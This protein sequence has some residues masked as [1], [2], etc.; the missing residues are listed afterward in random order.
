[1]TEPIESIAIIGGGIGGLNLAQALKLYKPSLQVTVYERTESPSARPQG[2]H[3]GINQWGQESLKEAKIAGIDEIFDRNTVTGFTVLD[4]NLKELLRI[5][6]PIP[7]GQPLPKFATRIIDRTDLRN[8]LVD[9]VHIEYNKKFTKYEELDDKIKIFFQDG[10]EVEA[11]F[12]VGAD[13]CWSKVRAQFVPSIKYEPTGIVSFGALMHG[14]SPDLMPTLDKFLSY[15]MI[16]TSTPAGYSVLMGIANPP[17]GKPDLFLGLSF[18]ESI[19]TEPLPEGK[20]EA[21][22]IVKGVIKQHFHPEVALVADSIQADQCLFNGFYKTHT[23][24]YQSRNPLA[25]VPHKRLTLLGDAA[26]G[27]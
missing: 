10:T 1:M 19:V 2:F 8:G 25:D 7:K 23:T 26:H 9:G 16:R 22:E 5:G 6:G 20:E 11:D 13:G 12:M 21:L 14:Y 18:P 24:N 4:E 17:T 3:I 15:S 27:K